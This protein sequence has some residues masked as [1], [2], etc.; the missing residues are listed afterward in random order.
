M[1]ARQNALSELIRHI[2]YS[3]FEGDEA[4][5]MNEFLATAPHAVPFASHVSVMTSLNDLAD[6]PGR[7]LADGESFSTGQKTWQWIDA[8]HVPHGWDCGVLFDQTTRTLL[9]GDLFTQPG[10]ETVPA[11]ESEILAASEA[12]R[13]PMD[14]FAHSTKTGTILNRLAL[15]AV[16]SAVTAPVSSR[17]WR[18]LSESGSE[19]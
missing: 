19:N 10:A 4:G 14:Y 6:R 3:H 11:T 1:A 5:A 15:G 2:G 9:C 7:D 8:P 13:K 16:Y 18:M 17:S 12:M